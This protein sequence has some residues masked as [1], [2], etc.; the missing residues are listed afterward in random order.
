VNASHSLAAV[1]LL[2]PTGCIS[3]APQEVAARADPAPSAEISAPSS[4]TVERPPPVVPT[5]APA[6]APAR[7]PSRDVLTRG[8]PPA[9]AP[10]IAFDREQIDRLDKNGRRTKL[11][12]RGAEAAALSPNQREVMLVAAP[13]HNRVGDEPAPRQLASLRLSDAHLTPLATL[14]NEA[15]G[16]TPAIRAFDQGVCVRMSRG[17]RVFHYVPPAALRE[18]PETEDSPC[19][20]DLP[21]IPPGRFT[22]QDDVVHDTKTGTALFK[23]FGVTRIAYSPDQKW[24]VVL[25]PH[26]GITANHYLLDLETD[27]AFDVTALNRAIPLQ[28]FEDAVDAAD[29]QAFYDVGLSNA[30]GTEPFFVGNAVLQA[31]A[32]GGANT[33]DTLVV[34]L[35]DKR[36]VRLQDTG[37]ARP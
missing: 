17:T 9:E 2:L 14:P 7:S 23:P 35:R 32:A 5:S 24:A 36:T 20:A 25:A 22:L 30:E 29:S 8:A 13:V 37:V 19:R 12:G 27:T 10:I 18:L 1:F 26:G 11:S 28:A 34:F 4:A 31:G 3:E 21:R 33:N 6:A 15:D 16:G